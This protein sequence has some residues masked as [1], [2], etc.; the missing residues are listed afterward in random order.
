MAIIMDDDLKYYEG[1]SKPSYSKWVRN[2]TLGSRSNLKNSE[3]KDKI[4][5]SN[6]SKRF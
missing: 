3:I 4:Y 5:K 6:F 1:K 2:G